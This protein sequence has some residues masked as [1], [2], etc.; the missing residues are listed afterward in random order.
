[1]ALRKFTKVEEAE[2]L[3]P[4]EHEEIEEGL[5]AAQKTSA[6]KLTIDE[7]KVILDPVLEDEDAGR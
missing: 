5:H 7:R 4:D 2:V 6:A 1:M 3:S